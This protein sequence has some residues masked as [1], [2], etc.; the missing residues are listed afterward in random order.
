[1]QN[2][3]EPSGFFAKST[4]APHSKEE[5]LMAPFY[6]ISSIY[7]FTNNSYRLWQ[8]SPF[9]MGSVPCSRGIECMFT[10]LL[11]NG[12]HF[13]SYLGNTLQNLCSKSHSGPWCSWVTPSKWGSAPSSRSFS[14]YK[15]FYRNRTGLLDFFNYP[16]YFAVLP[17]RSPPSRLYFTIITLGVNS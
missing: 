15:T 4:G 2:C 13:G 10:K 8:Y 12:T 9:H 16:L 1:M 7:Y 5:G 6:S 3:K 11:L 14:P 17:Y